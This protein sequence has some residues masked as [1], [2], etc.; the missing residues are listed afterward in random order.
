MT[1]NQLCKDIKNIKTNNTSI[2]TFS[3]NGKDFMF[4]GE[5]HSGIKQDISKLIN[6]FDGNILTILECNK[7]FNTLSINKISTRYKKIIK[8]NKSNKNDSYIDNH[9][10]FFTKKYKSLFNKNKLLKDISK[11]EKIKTICID[12]RKPA[13]F[14]KSQIRTVIKKDIKKFNNAKKMLLKTKHKINNM[15]ESNGKNILLNKINDIINNKL[16]KN[17]PFLLQVLSEIILDY[18]ILNNYILNNKHKEKYVI[19]IFGKN[20][21]NN[22]KKLI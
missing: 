21:I 1:F 10:L 8:D 7:G 18:E 17:S 19:G 20:H 5:V 3:K 13:D 16:K 14:P 6:D 22:I 12:E 9:L 11:S 4:I 2:L 15:E